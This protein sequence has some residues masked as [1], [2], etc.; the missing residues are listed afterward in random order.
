LANLDKAALAEHGI[1][2]LKRKL[3]F[4]MNTLN[5]R[6]WPNLL[7]AA[8]KQLNSRPMKKLHGLSPDAFNSVW[9]DP[10]LLGDDKKPCP[11]PNPN[12][13]DTSTQ[14]ANQHDY[15]TGSNQYQVDS[16][17]YVTP[18][19][20]KTFSKSFTLKVTFDATTMQ[21]ILMYLEIF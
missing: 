17:V 9:D 18:S 19:K 10:K 12:R 3:Y 7:D 13:P 21:V 2:L 15:E 11:S 6:N 14:V 4:M 20:T 8:L 16:F 5:D 1:Y